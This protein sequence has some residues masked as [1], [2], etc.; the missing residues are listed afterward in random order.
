MVKPYI[1]WATPME[2]PH[3]DSRRR[4]RGLPCGV[5]V[6]RQLEALSYGRAACS[7]LFTARCAHEFGKDALP[8][9]RRAPSRDLALKDKAYETVA[10]STAIGQRHDWH[11]ETLTMFDTKAFDCDDRSGHF[12][13]LPRVSFLFVLARRG[14]GGHTRKRTRAETAH[15]HVRAV[16]LCNGFVSAPKSVL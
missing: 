4:R 8:S 9:A 3:R 15:A 13:S 10:G 6:R 1:V 11:A 7:P 5:A 2:Q 12:C 16:S 14:E